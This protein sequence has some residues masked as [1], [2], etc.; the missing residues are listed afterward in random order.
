M[1]KILP[2]S[3]DAEGVLCR[4]F[5]GPKS[6]GLWMNLQGEQRARRRIRA[7]ILEQN[8]NS[9]KKQVRL[10]KLVWLTVR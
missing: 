3:I 4:K 5:K 1:K 8:E 7:L 10:R 2:K 9:M 6:I